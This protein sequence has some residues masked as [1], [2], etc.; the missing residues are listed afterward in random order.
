MD[1]D[2]CGRII[3][4]R[5]W[6]HH[7]EKCTEKGSRSQKRKTYLI[8]GILILDSNLSRISKIVRTIF[9]MRIL[10]PDKFFLMFHWWIIDA[11]FASLIMFLLHQCSFFSLHS[12]HKQFLKINTFKPPYTL[13][14]KFIIQIYQI[15][16]EMYWVTLFPA[17]HKY[18][19]IKI[20]L[21]QNQR[22]TLFLKPQKEFTKY[23][24]DCWR[25]MQIEWKKINSRPQ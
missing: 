3:P 24:L 10:Y 19:T 12:Q 23:R 5:H 15:F 21:M 17:V 13:G 20:V 2:L 9:K 16:S 22:P 4:I 18:R 25:C 1:C 14:K 6:A 11:M 7:I 8:P